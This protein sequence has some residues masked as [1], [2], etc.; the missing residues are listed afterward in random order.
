ML[1]LTVD[2]VVKRT[3]VLG[4]KILMSSNKKYVRVKHRYRAQNDDELSMSKK[5]VIQII[6][7]HDDGWWEGKNIDTG[8][9]G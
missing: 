1:S 5:Q 6:F 8:R 4:E 7:E 3:Q 9:T 2:T